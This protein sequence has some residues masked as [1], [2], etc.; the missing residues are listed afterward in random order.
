[1][2]KGQSSTLTEKTA[3]PMETTSVEPF[4]HTLSQH[5]L[6]LERETTSTL[7]VNVGLLC[8]QTCKHCH[9]DAGPNRREAMDRES[10]REVL[11]YAERCCFEVID[12]TG[13]APEVNPFIFDLVEGSA[14]LASQVMFRSNLSA[15]LSRRGKELM[16]RLQGSQVVIVASFPALN[17]S[18]ADAQR[19]E[20]VFHKSVAALQQLNA[21]GY[22]KPGSDLV[23]NLVS[24]P[25]GAFLTP[26]QTQAEK[27]F[28][29]VLKNKWD[30]HFNHLFN[31]ANVP[32]GR[33]RQWLMT[34]GNM[35]G[36]MKKLA[37]SFNPCA[38]EGL[39]CRTLISVSWDGFLFD[40]D[41]NVAAQ[42]G[43][44]GKRV[45]VS[46][47]DGPP[48]PGNPVAVGDHCYTC[49]AGAGFT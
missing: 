39:M 35:E 48:S 47:M 1:M 42:L 28:R 4:S 41:F 2:G 33:F 12:I 34:S 21:L 3:L 40:C 45:H 30:I 20:G 13:G 8:N 22:G 10:L 38:V 11:A 9:L 37:Q 14:S 46:Q 7:Q 15:L 5:G 16:K 27:R 23:L 19:G 17:V 32:L 44:G 49:T 36:Y 31:F 29:D 43:L 25:T 18:Q 24:N 6:R 26:S